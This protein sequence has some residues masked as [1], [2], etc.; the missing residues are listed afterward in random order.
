MAEVAGLEPRHKPNKMNR[1]WQSDNRRF[2]RVGAK[3]CREFAA[4]FLLPDG[5]SVFDREGAGILA[6]PASN[7][8]THDLIVGLALRRGDSSCVH[9]ER[10][11]ELA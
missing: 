5:R 11:P 9:I 6:F 3:E 1:L 8:H 4:P 10:D 7:T 2:T